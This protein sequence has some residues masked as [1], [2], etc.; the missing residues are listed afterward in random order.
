[1]S[2]EDRPLPWMIVKSQT[3]YPVHMLTYGSGK[4]CTLLSWVSVLSGPIVK[5][6]LLGRRSKHRTKAR[7]Q[8][9]GAW[10]PS[11]DGDLDPLT[12]VE[13]VSLVCA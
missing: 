6:G 4:T 8:V 3:Y 1:V 2:I 9:L 13:R 5:G 7:P 12:G 10:S 11:L